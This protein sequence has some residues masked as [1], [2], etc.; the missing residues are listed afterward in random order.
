MADLT[1]LRWRLPM[2]FLLMLLLFGMLG[3]PL[4]HF[5]AVH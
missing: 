4:A 5:I 1:G 3:D 2:A